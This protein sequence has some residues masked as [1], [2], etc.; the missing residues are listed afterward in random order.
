[1]LKSA[2]FSGLSDS[3][4]QKMMTCLGAK[5]EKFNI[6]EIPKILALS[7]PARRNW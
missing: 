6:T 3:E 1:M 2:V 7:F 5:E 4:A